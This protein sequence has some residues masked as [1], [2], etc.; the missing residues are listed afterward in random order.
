MTVAVRSTHSG[1]GARRAAAVVVFVLAAA[2]CYSP[3]CGLTACDVRTPDCQARAAAAAGCLRGLPAPDVPVAVVSRDQYRQQRL[4]DAMS[5]DQMQAAVLW[6]QALSLLGLA[7]ADPTI[8]GPVTASAD[9][10][11][12]FYSPE[13]KAITLI[14]DG[15]GFDWYGGV[16]LLVHEF[17]HALQDV[18]LGE[19]SAPP[20]A[21]D[22]DSARV[23]SAVFEG[24]ATLVQDRAQVGLFGDAPDDVDWDTIF[25]NWKGRAR[26]Q[27]ASSLYPVDLEWSYFDYPFGT[28]FV[29]DAQ[30][31]GGWAGVDA[32]HAAFPRST[33]QIM[34]G[35]GATPPAGFPS[36]DEDLATDAVPVLPPSF[37]FSD[38]DRMGAWVVDQLAARLAPGSSPAALSSGLRG[39]LLAI[40]REQTTGGMLVSWRLRFDDPAQA[41]NVAATL[42]PPRVA[43][44]Q[45]NGRDVVYVIVDPPALVAQLPSLL[46]FQARP[47]ASTP[48]AGAQGRPRMPSPMP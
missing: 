17:T 2:G 21:E 44:S 23:V 29:H 45:V 6:E 32:L 5:P 33:R 35:F 20:A 34:A 26:K 1:V 40:F 30:T 10:V 25:S 27:A 11:G 3:P 38:A 48:S 41:A 14:D 22:R 31:A 42:R 9:A 36:W 43:L 15:H 8:S 47:P 24:E 28:P 7:P 13:D 37:I 46:T 39:D 12:A 19:F 4:S 18:A 16:V